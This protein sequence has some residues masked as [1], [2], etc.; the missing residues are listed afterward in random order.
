LHVNDVR[1]V[2]RALEVWELTGRPL[3]AWQTQWPE[4]A[5]VDDGTPRILWLDLPRAELYQRL[6]ARVDQMLSEGLVEEVRALG[7]L[8]QPLSREAGQALGYKEVIDYLDGKPVWTP[9]PNV[10]APAAETMR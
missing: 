10:S 7:Q 5:R 2:I 8:P 9:P 1:R 4:T 6:D 3:S